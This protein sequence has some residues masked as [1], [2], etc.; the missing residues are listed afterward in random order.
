MPTKIGKYL[1]KRIDTKDGYKF[2]L[3]DGWLLIRPSGTEPL[4]RFYAE[5]SSMSIVN[6]VLENAMKLLK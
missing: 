1:V 4:I 2:Y 5:A 6:E 3:E